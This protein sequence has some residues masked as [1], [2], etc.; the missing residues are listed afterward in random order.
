MELAKDES[1]ILS[2]SNR[3]FKPQPLAEAFF[4]ASALSKPLTAP[5]NPSGGCSAQG[6]GPSPLASPGCPFPWG[7]GIFP[8]SPR[9]ER[10]ESKEE[11]YWAD[12]EVQGASPLPQC[13]EHE[14]GKAS[15][16]PPS[17]GCSSR[18]RDHRPLASPRCP[19]PWGK[20]I[21]PPLP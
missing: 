4:Y 1:S 2:T 18:A 21:S 7:K 6:K 11:A 20:G 17:G 15:C 13:G 8:A 9:R 10:R 14:A 19:F 12:G 3:Y 16:K 5:L